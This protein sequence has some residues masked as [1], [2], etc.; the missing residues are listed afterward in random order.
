[1]YIILITMNFYQ[2]CQQAN[3]FGSGR[4]IIFNS[5]STESN[6]FIVRYLTAACFQSAEMLNKNA[7]I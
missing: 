1:M 3:L 6:P 2:F 5:T 4:S 7:N